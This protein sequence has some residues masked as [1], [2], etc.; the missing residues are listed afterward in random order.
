MSDFAKSGTANDTAVIVS[1]DHGESFEGGVYQHSTPYLTRP[2]IHV[3]LVVRTPGQ[4]DGRTV[5]YTVDQTALAP[6][7]LGLAGQPKPNWMSG[8]SLVPWLEK[9][10][11]GDGEGTAF[12]QYLAKNDIYKPIKRRTLA[13]IEGG[14]QYIV[15][16]DTQKGELR[17][18]NEA[19]IWNLDRSAENPEKAAALRQT[20]HAK[21]PDLVKPTRRAI[22]SAAAE[23]CLLHNTAP[24][25][26]KAEPPTQPRGWQ[27]G[28]DE[29]HGIPMGTIHGLFFPGRDCTRNTC[30]ETQQAEN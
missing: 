30:N 14:Y 12:S 20:L 29:R 5:N 16:L 26:S 21:F 19:Q 3:P 22:W 28:H 27:S 10:G 9:N 17:P 2:V 18:L 15:Y 25:L 23:I 1:A 7:I 8:Q 11:Q 6:T 24:Q 13:V 4:Q